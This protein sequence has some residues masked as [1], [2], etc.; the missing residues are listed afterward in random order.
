MA[1]PIPFHLPTQ[2]GEPKPSFSAP[3]NGIPYS[4][5]FAEILKNEH[6]SEAVFLCKSGTQALELLAMTLFSEPGDEVIMPSY[7]FVGCATAFSQAGFTIVFVEIDPH[8]GCISEDAV[9]HALSSQT[10]VILSLNYASQSPDY[11]R[12]RK[13]ADERSIFL[14]EDNAHGLGANAYGRKL[15]TW[16]HAS[17]LS[18]DFLKPISCGEGG[19][20]LFNCPVPEKF[21]SHYLLGTN[22]Y[23]FMRGNVSHYEWTDRGTNSLISELLAH[24]LISEWGFRNEIQQRFLGIHQVYQST[25]KKLADEK[26]IELPQY[27]E[28]PGHNGYFFY[29]KAHDVIQRDELIQALSKEGISAYFHYSPLHLSQGG[30]RWGK[31]SGSMECTEQFSSRIVRLPHYFSLSNVQQMRICEVVLQF[32]QN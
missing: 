31:V 21:Y 12:L 2:A 22:K 7:A 15:G 9:V 5:E 10:R 23:A 20:I 1:A 27:E 29:F 18:F 26:K 24:W 25:I 13:I 11:P 32:Y 28:N 17:I 19:A 3:K 30:R 4:L 6:R 8:N 14:V 16:G